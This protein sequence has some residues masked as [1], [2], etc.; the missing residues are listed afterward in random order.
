MKKSAASHG[1]AVIVSM[2]VGVILV[3]FVRPGF[4]G[5]YKFFESFSLGLSDLIN[6]IFII[7]TDPAAFKPII[8]GL[9]IG[10]VWGMIYGL[11]RHRTN[12]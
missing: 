11:A 10:V 8:I 7:N 2:V 1:G 5:L 4:P 3:E 6:S 9:L 12:P